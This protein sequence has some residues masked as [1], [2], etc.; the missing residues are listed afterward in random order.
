M[1]R[2]KD[3][4]DKLIQYLCHKITLAQLIDWAENAMMDAEFDDTDFITIRD[5]ISR[6]GLADVK[7]FGLTWEDC[8]EFLTR[9]GYRVK[10]QFSKVA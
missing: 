3:V 9:L 4:A 1:I 8:E 7:A 6:V 10:I 5:V 2:Q